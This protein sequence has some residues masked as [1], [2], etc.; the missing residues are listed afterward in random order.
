[1]KFIFSFDDYCEENYKLA[2]LL[3][4]FNIKAIFFIDKVN[5]P[6]AEGQ[7]RW[8]DSKGHELGGHTINHPVLRLLSMELQRYEIVECK[9]LIEIAIH[10]KIEWFAYPKGKYNEITKE[11][12]KKAKYKYA[13]TVDVGYLYNVDNYAIKTTLHIYDRAEYNGKNWFDYGKYMIEKT[14]DL[15]DIDFHIWGHAWEIDKFEYWNK[16]K[17]FLT[18]IKKYET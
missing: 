4:E 15:K 3:A 6:I 13:R 18:L 11:L 14:K 9:K 1:M 7:V 2:N 12:V 10:K 8:L 17:E 5:N 16:F